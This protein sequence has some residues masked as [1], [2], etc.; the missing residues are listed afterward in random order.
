MNLRTIIGLGI[1][2]GILICLYFDQINVLF[3][4]MSGALAYDCLYAKYKLNLN[5]S[6]AIILFLLILFFH[7]KLVDL[8]H[9]DP[10]LAITIVIITQISDIYQYILGTYL[11]KNK[12]GWISQNKTYEGYFFGWLLTVITFSPAIYAMQYMDLAHFVKDISIWNCILF[13]TVDYFLGVLGGL[14]SSLFKR[15]SLIKDYSNL[16]GPHGGWVDRIDSIVLP[17]LAHSFCISWMC[18]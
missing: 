3:Y 1:T 11:G 10:L 7:Y 5:Y 14:I 2:F 15:F 8:Y 4:A 13:V 9:Y 12:I 18:Y 17:S 16:L 6:K